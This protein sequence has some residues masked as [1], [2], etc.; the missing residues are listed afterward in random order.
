[1]LWL[2]ELLYD[3]EADPNVEEW[4]VLGV[5]GTPFIAV[6]A[7]RAVSGVGALIIDFFG[8]SITCFGLVLRLDDGVDRALVTTG[9]C[10]R[11]PASTKGW[12]MADCGFIRRSGSQT[13]HLAMKSTNSSSLHLSACASVLDPGRRLRPFEF[14][15][16]LG[17]PLVSTQM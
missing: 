10:L 7:D 2:C 9:T 17:A 6:L 12:R 14:T 15:T 1:M 3:R 11:L 5:V 4:L 16:G 8:V 13:R